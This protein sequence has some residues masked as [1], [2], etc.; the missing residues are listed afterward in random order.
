MARKS[1]SMVYVEPERAG[2]LM[3][4]HGKLISTEL[5]KIEQQAKKEGRPFC[6]EYVLEQVTD[7]AHPLHGG[8]AWDDADAGHRFRLTQARALII[9]AKVVYRN[10]Q[11]LLSS[12][13]IVKVRQYPSMGKGEGFGERA[14]V[15][16]KDELRSQ[17][18][19]GKLRMVRSALKELVDVPGAEEFVQSVTV[20][21]DNLAGT[22]GI[23]IG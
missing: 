5:A 18:V 23:D 3:T 10:K 1:D 17:H 14:T 8:F 13:A 4:R 21:V 22:F 19:R 12:P 20:L 15:L 16:S 6:G 2:E 11:K 9:A 7:P